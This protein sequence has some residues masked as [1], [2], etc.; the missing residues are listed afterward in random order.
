MGIPWEV[1]KRET[2]CGWGWEDLPSFVGK[3]W[4]FR[5]DMRLLRGCWV[6]TLAS[7]QEDGRGMRAWHA[8]GACKL[9]PCKLFVWHLGISG[10]VEEPPLLSLAVGSWLHTGKAVYALL[11]HWLSRRL[12]GHPQNLARS[13]LNYSW[14]VPASNILTEREIRSPYEMDAL[15][16]SLRPISIPP[17]LYNIHVPMSFWSVWPKQLH[18]IEWLGQGSQMQVDKI[19]FLELE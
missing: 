6:L 17:T 9:P 10:C 12:P 14:G 19:R 3:W 5:L 16:G 1:I 15:W 8:R 4:E 18:H 13:Q 2:D 7:G 11:I